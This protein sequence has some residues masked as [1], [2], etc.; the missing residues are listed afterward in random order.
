MPA[1]PDPWKSLRKVVEQILDHGG[2]T[3][4]QLA[5]L[6]ISVAYERWEAEQELPGT[7]AEQVLPGTAA[8]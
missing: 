5:A 2:S 3:C 8:A 6:K 4:P 1:Q 7:A